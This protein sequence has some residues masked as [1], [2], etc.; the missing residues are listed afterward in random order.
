[1]TRP[2]PRGGGGAAVVI[3]ASDLCKRYG[4]V[5]AVDG[6]DL[7]VEAGDIYALLG[8]NGAGK[9]TTIPIPRSSPRSSS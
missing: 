2:D 4:P 3:A 1:M 5:S 8:L 6:V 7:R 9:T